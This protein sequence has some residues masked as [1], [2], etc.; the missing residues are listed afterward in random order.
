MFDD[1]L[2]GNP[3]AHLPTLL[4]GVMIVPK[5]VLNSSKHKGTTPRYR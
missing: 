5:P 4:Y 1:Y 2:I 3:I